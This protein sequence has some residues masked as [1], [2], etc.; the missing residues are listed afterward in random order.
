MALPDIVCRPFDIV[1][2]A[3]RKHALRTSCGSVPSAVYT[4]RRP[5]SI[6]RDLPPPILLIHGLSAS[7][8]DDS[9]VVRLATALTLTGATVI[10]PDIAHLRRLIVDNHTI[11]IITSV[12]VAVA[13]DAALCSGRRARLSLCAPCISAGIVL[14]AAAA[15]A[16]T[17]PPFVAILLIGP[18]ATM[19]AIHDWVFSD[20]KNADTYGRNSILLNTLHLLNPTQLSKIVSAH[21]PSEVQNTVAKGSWSVE[22]VCELLR[23]L[24]DDDHGIRPC[25]LPVALATVSPAT[26]AVFRAVTCNPRVIADLGSMLKGVPAVIAHYEKISPIN[27][28]EAICASC[29]VLVHGSADEV[30]PPI[31]TTILDSFLR[32]CRSVRHVYSIISPILAHGENVAFD[33]RPAFILRIVMNLINVFSTFFHALLWS[34]W[35]EVE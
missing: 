17:L 21:T 11:D 30:I 7:G 13:D 19:E 20:D 29:V 22:D 4:P 34:S 33:R 14:V 25:R 12:I 35:H 24:L 15:L 23:A 6:T 10:V 31:E 32:K 26:Q 3:R 27:S 16:T 18:Y 28:A 2:V 9:R 5:I 8:P 1:T